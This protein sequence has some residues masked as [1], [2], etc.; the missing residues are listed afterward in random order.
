MKKNYTALLAIGVTSMASA[1]SYLIDFST[2]AGTISTTEAWNTI[3]G[4][5]LTDISD[6]TGGASTIDLSYSVAGGSVGTTSTSTTGAP[7]TFGTADAGFYNDGFYAIDQSYTFTL[8]GLDPTKT[9]NFEFFGSR[10]STE[11]RVATYTVY[12][13]AGTPGGG[14]AVTLANSGTD[15]GGTGINHNIVSVATVNGVTA[16]V[17][18][19]IYFDFAKDSGFAAYLNAVKITAVPE[20]SSYALLAGLSALAAIAIRRRA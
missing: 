1:Q 10:D 8:A 15:L 19:E 2:S 4:S 11:S 3:G 7:S 14:T 9:Y 17:S 6:S 12:T 16:N 5:P 20:P 18:N 13:A